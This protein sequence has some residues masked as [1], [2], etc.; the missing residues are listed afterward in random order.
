MTFGEEQA[1]AIGIEVKKTKWILLILSASLTGSAI[2]FAGVIG[3]IDLI[4]PHVVRK[5]FGST[6][7]LVLPMSMLF[8]GTF[9]V[10]CDLVARIII[11]N[12]E[13]P[14]G[15]VTALIGAPFL[16]YVYFTTRKVR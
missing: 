10:V 11:P 14:V 15:A 7:K 16:A 1:L 5:I 2:A 4:A 13:L 3:F 9:M 12:S 6:H 8:G